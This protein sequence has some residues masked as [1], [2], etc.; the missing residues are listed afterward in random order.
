MS[1]TNE[2]S[3]PSDRRSSVPKT[4]GRAVAITA[5]GLRRRFGAT[6]AIDG[7]DLEVKRGEV[8]GFLGPNGAGK[9]TTMRML[10]GL[11][12]PTAGRATVVGAAPGKRLDKVGSLVEAP[13]FYP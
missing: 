10:V 6:M 1:A 8:Y 9:S 3:A 5:I 13:A 4:D 7:L 12:R 2:Y 11:M